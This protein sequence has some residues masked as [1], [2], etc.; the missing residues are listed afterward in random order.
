MNTIISTQTTDNSIIEVYQDSLPNSVNSVRLDTD[1]TPKTGDVVLNIS[2]LLEN[3]NFKVLD[4][5]PGQ[6]YKKDQLIIYEGTLYVVREDFTAGEEFDK[7]NYKLPNEPEPEFDLPQ[8]SE[9]QSGVSKLYSSLGEN[10][11]GSINQ[12]VV[13]EK[14]D[15]LDKAAKESSSSIS[16][17]KTNINELNNKIENLPSSGVEVI[18]NDKYTQ[19][20]YPSVGKKKLQDLFDSRLYDNIEM[21]FVFVPNSAF[22]NPTTSGANYINIIQ[23]EE[24]L[25]SGRGYTNLFSITNNST[26]LWSQTPTLGL[27]GYEYSRIM[28]SSTVTA[29]QSL[30]IKY[31][32]TT[33]LQRIA[34]PSTSG[35]SSNMCWACETKTT[36]VSQSNL[37]SLGVKNQS[38]EFSETVLEDF[39]GLAIQFNSPSYTCYYTIKGVKR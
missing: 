17:I 24:E 20:T 31:F 3:T 25:Q 12:K 4:F 37:M 8:A 26:T 15:S 14:I 18:V 23:D 28:I 38:L 21:N 34:S 30:N 39:N 19:T 10:E 7:N 9:S 5:T 29:N 27:N 2:E 32:V 22:G 33:K 16:Q 1:K 11:D 35:F 13:S 6:T 36:S